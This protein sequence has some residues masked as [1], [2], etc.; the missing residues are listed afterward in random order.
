MRAQQSIG[1]RHWLNIALLVTLLCLPTAYTVAANNKEPNISPWTGKQLNRVN[2]LLADEQYEKARK[3]LRD[4]LD[5]VE[6]NPYEAGIV[7]QAFA[8]TYALQDNYPFAIKHFENALPL[9]KPSPTQAQKTR[10]DLAQLYMAENAYKKAIPLLQAWLS[11]TDEP[12]ALAHILLG[13]AYTQLEQPTAALPHV[14]K[15]IALA[16]APKEYWYQLLLSLYMETEQLNAGVKLLAKMIEL[17]PET[18][19]YWKQLGAI[20]IQL[21]QYQAGTAAME[22]AWQRNLLKRESEL[23]NLANLLLHLELPEKAARLLEIELNKQHIEPI[24]KNWRLLGNA[25]LQARETT[26]AIAAFEK[27]AATAEDGN[28]YERIAQLYVDKNQWRNALN[29]LQK[30]LEK[31]QLK[32]PGGYHLL[33]GI[34]AYELNEIQ[35]A[36]QYFKKATTYPDTQQP[37]SQWLSFIARQ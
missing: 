31:G 14:K 7:Q 3:T 6:D 20:H 30:G 27:A 24:D 29:A 5:S 15:A 32:N 33:L 12:K 26:Q 34:S 8:Y 4:L 23:L 37:A 17:F 1:H 36:Q 2:E 22:I 11:A 16:E 25:L 18:N 35:Q 13:N 10:F 19:V 21:K 28:L 9:L